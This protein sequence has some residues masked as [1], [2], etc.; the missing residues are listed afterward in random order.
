MRTSLFSGGNHDGDTAM[1]TATVLDFSTPH[2]LRNA[3]EYKAAV[4]EIDQHLAAEHH[5]LPTLRGGRRAKAPANIRS[6]GALRVICASRSSPLHGRDGMTCSSICF[7]PPGEVGRARLNFSDTRILGC[8][9]LQPKNGA[10][11]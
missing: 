10:K 5:G 4:T 11:W 2:V 1:A 6:F 9:I 3:R 7:V 8:R